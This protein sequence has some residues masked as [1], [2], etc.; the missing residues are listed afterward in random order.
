MDEKMMLMLA[1]F[2][3][4]E[5]MLQSLVNSEQDAIA[6]VNI[7]ETLKVL[8]EFRETLKDAK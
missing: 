7:A 6:R 3:K 2:D 4:L 1:N 8:A 5:E